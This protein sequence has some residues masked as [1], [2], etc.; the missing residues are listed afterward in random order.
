M[1]SS[2]TKAR[3]RSKAN[4]TPSLLVR[5]N[6]QLRVFMYV[7]VSE[8][9]LLAQLGQTLCCCG[10]GGHINTTGVYLSDKHPV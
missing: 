3:C 1:L 9:Q 4:S 6:L 7:E 8:G 2:V 5:S 10:L